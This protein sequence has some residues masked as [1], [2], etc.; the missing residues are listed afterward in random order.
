MN[1]LAPTIVLHLLTKEFAL[2]LLEATVAAAK[3]DTLAM[4]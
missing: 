1:A 3:L 4:V 2:I